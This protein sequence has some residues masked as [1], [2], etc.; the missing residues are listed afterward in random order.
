MTTPGL[1]PRPPSA[2][3]LRPIEGGDLAAIGPEGYELGIDDYDLDAEGYER[4]LGDRFRASV[5]RQLIRLGWLGLAAGIALGS[6]GIVAAT[7]PA[8]S[9]GIRTELTYSADRA[10]SDRLDAAVRDLARLKDDVDSLGDMTR[11]TL[12]SLSQVN[13]PALDEASLQGTNDINS[14]DSAAATLNKSLDCQSWSS[15]RELELRKV[16]SSSVVDRYHS[17]CLAIESVAPLRGDW[18]S[19]MAGS[20]TA[21]R[22]ANDV[23]SHDAAAADALVLATQGRY[24]EAI[25]KLNGASAAIT[26]ASS[27]ADNLAKITDVSTLTEWMNRTKQMDDA[28]RL[29]WQTMITSKGKVTAQ[30][31][32]AL[33]AVADAKALL[34]T[35]T[36]VLPVVM[37]ELAGQLTSDGI[38][39]ETAKGALAD[40]L[41]NLVGGTA[42][43]A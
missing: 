16:N 12:A 18:E 6:A 33:K 10:L 36:D 29:L 37:Y 2:S 15:A 20:Q 32:A 31:T 24:P 28:L 30:V 9:S 13:A 42:G 5:G 23:N 4:T 34:P 26:D 21:M 14:I 3:G 43:G 1:P 11:K 41:A 39:I 27:I 17:I 22:V 38:S 35:N 7:Q 40:A 8:P 25:D 19:L